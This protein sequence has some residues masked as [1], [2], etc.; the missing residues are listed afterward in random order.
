MLTKCRGG[1]NIGK[2]LTS[3]REILGFR[4]RPE[5]QAP[6]GAQVSQVNQADAERF[7]KIEKRC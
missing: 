4:K 2:S 1:G 5:S 7:K 6:Q 3:G